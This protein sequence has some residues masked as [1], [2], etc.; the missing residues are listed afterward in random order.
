LDGEIQSMIALSTSLASV[1]MIE[2]SKIQVSGLEKR[3]AN[4]V[5]MKPGENRHT[6]KTERIAAKLN[7][8][9]IEFFPSGGY[10]V[11]DANRLK[12]AAAHY[13]DAN[14]CRDPVIRQRATRCAEYLL[15]KLSKPPP[16]PRPPAAAA[17]QAAQALALLL[18]KPPDD[19]G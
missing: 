15:S 3:L 13:V 11:M 4:L 8:L 16:A 19:V 14:L 17:D 9:V 5:P 10:S 6:R 2:W 7:E 18:N 1:S 12:L